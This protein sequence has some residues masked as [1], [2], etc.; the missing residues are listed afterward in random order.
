MI[1]I[2][3]FC[4]RS[5]LLPYI[6]TSMVKMYND[7]ASQSPVFGAGVADLSYSGKVFDVMAAK[8]Y[9][10]P[11]QFRLIDLYENYSLLWDRK[12]CPYFRKSPTHDLCFPL[13]RDLVY[14]GM[15][16]ARRMSELSSIFNITLSESELFDEIEKYLFLIYLGNAHS[17]IKYA[18]NLAFCK[19]WKLELPEGGYISNYGMD[20]FPR[21]L[22]VKMNLIISRKRE[23]RSFVNQSLFLTLFQGLKKGLLP[24]PIS[25]LQQ[26]LNKHKKCLTQDGSISSSLSDRIQDKM[27][28]MTKGWSFWD[29]LSNNNQSGGSTLSSNYSNGGNIGYVK[30]ILYG[31]YPIPNDTFIGFIYRYG[32]PSSVREVRTNN[33]VFT[34]DMMSLFGSKLLRNI[35]HSNL[36]DKWWKTEKDCENNLSSIVGPAMILEPMKVRMITKPYTGTHVEMHAFQRRLWDLLYNRYNNFFSLIG[37]ELDVTHLYRFFD[38]GWDSNS[39]MVS[40]DYS[41]A[42]D[43]L[44]GE[45]TRTI[46]RCLSNCGIDDRDQINRLRIRQNIEL[47]LCDTVID[48]RAVALPDYGSTYKGY[49]LKTSVFKQTN[50]QLMGHVLSFPILCLANFIC[51]WLSLE[52]FQG[53]DL[54]LKDIRSSHPVLINGDDILFRST[55]K[56]YEVWTYKVNQFGF[57]PSV[58]KNFLSQDVFQIN[59]KT[60]RIDTYLDKTSLKTRL[61]GLVKI[62]YINF[63]LITH[64][65]KQDC[66]KDLTVTR[67]VPSSILK[68]TDLSEQ[69]FLGVGRIGVLP[70]IYNMFRD[71]LPDKIW[72]RAREVLKVHWL[73]LFTEFGVP[74]YLF[75]LLSLPSMEDLFKSITRPSSS[76]EIGVDLFR[77]LQNPRITRVDREPNPGYVRCLRKKI[78]TNPFGISDFD[79][80]F[81]DFVDEPKPI[82]IRL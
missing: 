8:G 18:I 79:G 55:Q 69:E 54:T 53:K 36:P 66:S 68:N 42:T 9:R 1:C 29:D 25:T 67:V 3:E 49:S 27:R 32:D 23:T 33:P 61:R 38:E 65:N 37:E 16:F 41:S 39:Y 77:D 22:R 82:W 73:P 4:S 64:R 56:Q 47:S 52:E 7:W 6:T 63:G 44:K 17:E 70:R 24:V 72:E 2:K 20:L 60:Y 31:E 13:V 28:I 78:L 45:I 11:H 48:H 59:S 74:H 26:S 30:K 76:M 19:F 12:R 35:E 75:D 15:D 40:G 34:S 62:P 50:G 51:Y 80:L 58:G 46:F 81:V 21:R 43:L 57:L 10:I 71:S 14:Q 5:S